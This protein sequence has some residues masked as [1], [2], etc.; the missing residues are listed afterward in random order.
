MTKTFENSFL[1]LLG[2]SFYNKNGP[3]NSKKDIIFSVRDQTEGFFFTA[4]NHA[5]IS[6]VSR[7]K[8]SAFPLRKSIFDTKNYYLCVI[9][10]RTRPPTTGSGICALMRKPSRK[11][12]TNKKIHLKSLALKGL[13]GNRISEVTGTKR[14]FY[15]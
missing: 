13:R 3:F 1:I 10:W 8:T 12:F 11:S 6:T 15:Q 7:H 4:V 2:F 14:Y 9:S 5:R